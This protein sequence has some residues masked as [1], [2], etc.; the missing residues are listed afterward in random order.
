[1]PPIKFVINR[2]ESACDEGIFNVF[3]RLTATDAQTII[4]VDKLN[5][6]G[7]ISRHTKPCLITWVPVN[8]V[9]NLKGNN[10]LASHLWD[11][12]KWYCYERG[13]DQWWDNRPL[14][15]AEMEYLDAHC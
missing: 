6:S 11:Y 13:F 5:E 2:N 9:I 4:R 12:L 1:M 10:R 8:N 15:T 3:D 7:Y 14:T